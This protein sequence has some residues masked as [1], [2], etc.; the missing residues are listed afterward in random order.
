MADLKVILHA[1]LKVQRAA[2]R[3]KL[4]GISER[5]AR[6][7]RTPTTTNLLGL[8]KHAACCEAGYFGEVFDRPSGIPMPWE[9]PGASLED[10]L[11]MFA[12]EGESMADVLAFADACF[13]HADSTI[14]SLP[15]DAP[16][17]VPWWRPGAREVVLGQII[18]HMALDEARHAGHADILREQ[19]DAAVG[20]RPSGDN[21]PDIDADAW[22][23]RHTR[24]QRI[25]D[26][27]PDD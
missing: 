25:A 11:D 9:A 16:G 8:L 26:S 2:L 6:L 10:D 15:I 21:L 5:Q 12:T 19:L 23:R 27:C 22:A 13:S 3:Q 14:E 1:Q 24:L 7:P 4:D 17:V 20:L 18:S